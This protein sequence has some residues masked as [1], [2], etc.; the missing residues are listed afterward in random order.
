M[1]FPK[2]ATEERT[3]LPATYRPD[4]VARAQSV[5][6]KLP[7]RRAETDSLCLLPDS[8]LA[9]LEAACLFDIMK[10]AAYGGQEASL[11]T[12]MDCILAL[13]KGDGAVGWTVALLNEAAWGVATFYREE[14][15]TPI[16]KARKPI[17]MAGAFQS[18]SAKVRWVEDGVIIDA[19][20]WSF[21]SG[22]RHADWVVLGLPILD[23]S[24]QLVQQLFAVMPVTDVEI[25]NDWDTIGLRG[26]GSHSVSLSNVFVPVERTLDFATILRGEYGSAHL[27][28][29]ALYR[30]PM[31]PLF[32]T[33]LGF[34]GLGIAM[35]VVEEFIG[36]ATRRGIV[37]TQ[38]GRQSD[39]AV[40]HLQT[41]EV[42]A[43]I[44]CAELLLRKNV[45][46][47]EGGSQRMA[48]MPLHMRA[49][50]RRNA[51]Y[52]NKLLGE[53]VDIII[54]ASGGSFTFVDHPLNRLWRDARVAGMHA[55]L[56]TASG[57]ELYGR[58]LF[59]LDPLTPMV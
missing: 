40:T 45:A 55:G 34:T 58:V 35:A 39:A 7:A 59:G 57:L 33:T 32:A 17:R 37:Y 52:A 30:M 8:T 5:A 13:A 28:D 54:T 23:E 6:G 24:G 36:M 53:A 44:E 2:V 48:T 41:A 16:F 46:T 49:E 50:I 1:N 14:I 11:G 25:V 43:K 18:K 10:P 56:N 21:V 47:I 31:I 51:A 26:T 4:L 29:K 12:L 38:Y 9:D 22:I 3:R 20:R 19:G 15:A 27:D 42:K